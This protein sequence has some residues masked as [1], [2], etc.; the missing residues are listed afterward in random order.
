MNHLLK[1]STL[2]GALALAQLTGCANAQPVQAQGTQVPVLMYHEIVT[3]L[4]KPPGETVI[5]LERFA[6]QMKFLSEHGYTPISTDELVR[7]M[8][9]GG[10]LP[11]RPVVLTFDDGW[12]NVLNAVPVL[13]R[14]GFKASFWIITGKG[15]GDD[16]MVWPDVEA[17]AKHPGFEVQSHTVSHPWDHANNLVTWV[18]DAAKGKSGGPGLDGARHELQD[19]KKVLQEHLGQPVRFLAWPCGWYND[20]LVTLAQEAGY[21]ALLTAESG[22][23]TAGGDVLHIKRTFI[24]GS[25]DMANFAQTLKDGLYHVCQTAQATTQGHAPAGS[26]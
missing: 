14:Y 20:T 21:E 7:F 4:R 8:R 9:S 23:N 26:K 11:P 17:L 6:E 22:M 13:D 2:A 19:S 12:K 1:L 24:D 5:T 15:I 16:Y 25:C 3:D 18:D 10:T